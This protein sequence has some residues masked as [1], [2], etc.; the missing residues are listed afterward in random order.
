MLKAKNNKIF[1]PGLG[2]KPSDYKALLPYMNIIKVDWNNP[3]ISIKKT[4]VLVSFS[5]GSLFAINWANKLKVEKIILCSPTPIIFDKYALSAQ[6][7]VIC[8]EKEHDCIDYARNYLHIEPIIIPKCGHKMT[9]K[10][11]KELLKH[12]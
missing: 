8:G 4:D 11:R 7:I 12:I 10:Y 1:I 6:L 3:K 9:E 5:L 2:E